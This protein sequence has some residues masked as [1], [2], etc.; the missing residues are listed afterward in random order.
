MLGSDVI[1]HRFCITELIEACTGLLFIPPDLDSGGFVAA[2]E[3]R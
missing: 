2:L 1:V 3:K